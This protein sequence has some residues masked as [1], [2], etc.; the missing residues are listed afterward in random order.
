MELPQPLPPH[1]SDAALRAAE[2]V[3]NVTKK[4]AAPEG[5]RN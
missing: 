2:P 1:W 3:E 4:R 5:R